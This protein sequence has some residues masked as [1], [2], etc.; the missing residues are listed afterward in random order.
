MN[1]Y[2][3]TVVI[4]T[5]NEENRIEF[6]LKNFN[7][8]AN[9]LVLDDGSTDKTKEICDKYSVKFLIR[10]KPE[11]PTYFTKEISGWILDNVETEYIFVYISYGFY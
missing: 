6:V 4:P 5:F 10:P 11:N 9:I 8:R 7:K 1:K 2:N 3:Y